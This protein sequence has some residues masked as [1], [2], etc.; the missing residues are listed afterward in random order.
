MHATKAPH[1]NRL[2]VSFGTLTTCRLAELADI[3]DWEWSLQ[4]LRAHPTQQASANWAERFRPHGVRVSPPIGRRRDKRNSFPDESRF[5]IWGAGPTRSNS[6]R[7]FGAGADL[8][9]TQ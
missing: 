8:R 2:L 3:D 1:S 4:A 7:I 5:S 6:T 9:P